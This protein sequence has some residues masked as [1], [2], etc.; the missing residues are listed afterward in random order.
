MFFCR[1]WT[2][3]RHSPDHRRGRSGR[4]P[5]GTRRCPQTPSSGQGRGLAVTPGGSWAVGGRGETATPT[6]PHAAPSLDGATRRRN[7]SL[8]APP[9]VAVPTGHFRDPAAGRAQGPWERPVTGTRAQGHGRRGRAFRFQKEAAGTRPGSPGGG[10]FPHARLPGPLWGRGRGAWGSVGGW[11]RREGRQGGRGRLR[12]LRVSPQLQAWIPGI[13][14]RGGGGPG[15][16]RAARLGV[17]TAEAPRVHGAGLTQGR[18]QPRAS[19]VA[20]GRPL[21]SL[22]LSFPVCGVPNRPCL[23]LCFRGRGLVWTKGLCRCDHV[24]DGEVTPGDDGP[25]LDGQVLTED[26]QERWQ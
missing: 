21:T 6:Q 15:A 20:R 13:L 22:G 14:W 19:C 8:P 23:W 4:N 24:K 2:R 9:T 11:L 18:P 10:P 7:A 5:P 17:S 26:A 16:F 12:V 3:A 1:L 25:S